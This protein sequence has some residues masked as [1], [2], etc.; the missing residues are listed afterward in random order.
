MSGVYHVFKNKAYLNY[1]HVEFLNL[2]VLCLNFVHFHVLFIPSI[3]SFNFS[4]FLSY[5]LSSALYIYFFLIYYFV[6]SLRKLIQRANYVTA[7]Y[8]ILP[9]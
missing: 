8:D 3:L 7:W 5:M 6:Y 9:C 1:F 4:L 2:S